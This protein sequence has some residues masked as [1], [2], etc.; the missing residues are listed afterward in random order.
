MSIDIENAFV[1][2]SVQAAIDMCDENI[3][4]FIIGGGTIYEQ[5]LSVADKLYI[6][7]VY[8]KFDA[9][10]FFPEIDTNKFILDSESE[11]FTDEKSELE[12]SFFIY[13]KNEIA[14]LATSSI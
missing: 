3:E 1:V 2:N 7:K 8:Q 5:F 6:T 4:N 12:Y 10:I 13:K 11:I 9:D 14:N